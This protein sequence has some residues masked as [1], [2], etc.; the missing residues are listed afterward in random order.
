MLIAHLYGIGYESTYGITRS[1]QTPSFR[2]EVSR[3]FQN[4]ELCIA[5]TH[6]PLPA[7][8]K[9]AHPPVE[10]WVAR[11]DVTAPTDDLAFLERTSQQLCFFSGRRMYIVRQPFVSN[12]VTVT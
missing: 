11:G 5:E 9:A 12:T 6:G 8:K 3:I 1:R 10:R 7:H 2:Q 4:V